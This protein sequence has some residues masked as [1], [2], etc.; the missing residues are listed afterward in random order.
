[1]KIL[2]RLTY[3]VWMLCLLFTSCRSDKDYPEAMQKAI[4]C[5]ESHPDSAQIY[6][7]SL[8]KQIAGESEETQ[9]YYALLTT[10]AADKLYQ[11]HTTDTIMKQVVDFYQK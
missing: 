6:L 11:M 3:Y 7:A 5:M 2:F 8:D 9:M 1:M 4:A 10:Q